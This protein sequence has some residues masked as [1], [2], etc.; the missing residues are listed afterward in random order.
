MA[1]LAG[2]LPK[3]RHH[4]RVAVLVAAGA[5]AA[6]ITAILLASGGQ[7]VTQHVS[8]TNVSR[9]FKVCLLTTG[10]PDPA[11]TAAWQAI[12]T[13]RI[14][15]DVN[16]Q[17]I[18]APQGDGTDVEPYVNSLIALKCEIIVTDEPPLDS[19]VRIVAQ[20][21]PTQRFIHIGAGLHLPNVTSVPADEATRITD[22]I[23][24]AAQKQ[25][26]T[27]PKPGR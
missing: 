2:F 4:W 14:R 20:A 9:N 1:T 8:Y 11:T 15:A 18:V 3:L 27:M 12:E 25:N 21:N 7:T 22:I 17:H 13:A 26:A 10:S 16:A 5:A 24:A 19:V 23:V 6:I